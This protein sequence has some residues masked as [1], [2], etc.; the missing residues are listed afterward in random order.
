MQLLKIS[1]VFFLSVVICRAAMAVPQTLLTPAFP[2]PVELDT[3]ANFQ[4]VATALSATLREAL[5]QGSSKFG[6]FTPNTE[7]VSVTLKSTA[8]QK[9]LFDFQFTGSGLNTG[10]G[11]TNKVSGDSVFRIGSISKLFTVYALLLN[12][13][14][15]V[16][17]HPVTRYVPE[18]LDDVKRFRNSSPIE[19]ANWDDITIG[20]LASQMSGIGVNCGFWCS[21]FAEWAVLS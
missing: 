4:S 3:D 12:G 20:A 17:E 19:H 16:W 8:Q 1:V 10:A 15:D 14:L 7:S 5:M 6:N 13:G 21:E 11:S 2:A 9:S 18:L